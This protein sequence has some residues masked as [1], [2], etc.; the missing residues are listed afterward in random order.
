[1]QG[2][3]VKGHRLYQVPS[4]ANV[5]PGANVHCFERTM[6]TLITQ[7]ALEVKD[8][9][10]IDWL[11]SWSA[12]ILL[13]GAGIVD[14]LFCGMFKEVFFLVWSDTQL[15]GRPVVNCE[16]LPAFPKHYFFEIPFQPQ[17][18]AQIKNEDVLK[19]FYF[20]MSFHHALAVPKEGATHNGTSQVYWDTISQWNTLQTKICWLGL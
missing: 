11:C 7:D 2:K 17:F 10:D 4:A 9:K 19:S 16:F 13:R 6:N 15:F 14:W 5:P 12:P 3:A 20:C 18:M 1:M 8:M